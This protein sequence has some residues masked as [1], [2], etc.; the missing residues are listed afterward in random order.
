MERLQLSHVSA[1]Q[2]G[3]IEI[4]T[5]R[6]QIHFLSDILIAVA[7]LDLKVPSVFTG[8]Y[9]AKVDMGLVKPPQQKGC[10]PQYARDKLVELQEKFDHLE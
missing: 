5:E 2:V 7:L 10:L 8:P 3:I 9:Q 1:K 6:T 4:K